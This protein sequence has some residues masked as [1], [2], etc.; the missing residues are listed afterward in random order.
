MNNPMAVVTQHG[1]PN[2]DGDLG[3][4]GGWLCKCKVVV[5]NEQTLEGS[6]N[7]LEHFLDSMVGKEEGKV[8]RTN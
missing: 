8:V 5:S 2:Y 6:H 4:R 1:Q 7:S 3:R